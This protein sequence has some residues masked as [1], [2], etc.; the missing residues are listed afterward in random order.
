MGLKAAIR[1]SDRYFHCN[2]VSQE[3]WTHILPAARQLQLSFTFWQDLHTNKLI[4]RE[5]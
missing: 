5:L 4:G 1:Q 3:A 2:H